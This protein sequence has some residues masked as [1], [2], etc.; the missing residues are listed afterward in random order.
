MQAGACPPVE[1]AGHEHRARAYARAYDCRVDKFGREQLR[2][3]TPHDR[4]RVLGLSLHSLVHEL[5]NR[6]NPMALQLAILRRRVPSPSED[7]QE[8]LDG[9]R[10]SITRAHETLDLA[11]RLASELAPSR[12][13]DVVDHRLWEQLCQSTHPSPSP[14]RPESASGRVI[15]K[16]VPTPST[17]S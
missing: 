10:E 4:E 2:D 3:L 15:S 14:S 8:V 13:D 11:S 5:R 17:D 9:L 7:L 12:G 16:V 1:L 6:I